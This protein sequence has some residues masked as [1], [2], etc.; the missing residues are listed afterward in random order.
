M[1]HRALAVAVSGVVLVGALVLSIVAVVQLSEVRRDAAGAGDRWPL[2]PVFGVSYLY[3]EGSVREPS[4]CRDDDVHVA[5]DSVPEELRPAGAARY[6][7]EIRAC[8]YQTVPSVFREQHASAVLLP[9]YG[10]DAADHLSVAL[11]NGGGD[12]DA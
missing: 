5:L 2:P 7:A 1:T 10:P 12:F 9:A 3:V 8:L 4:P 11:V 6:D